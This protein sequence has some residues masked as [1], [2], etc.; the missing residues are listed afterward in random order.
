MQVRRSLTV[1]GLGAALALTGGPAWAE[2]PE[3]LPEG[4]SYVDEPVPD[5]STGGGGVE[6]EPAPDETGTAE[7]EPDPSATE[8]P[9]VEDPTDAPTD[10]PTDEPA[11][12]P[13]EEPGTDPTGG[14]GTGGGQVVVCVTGAQAGEGFTG[15]GG[16][17]TAVPGQAPAQLPTTG[18]STGSAALLGLSL[19][20]GGT[21]V[22][23]SARQPRRT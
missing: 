19:L 11:D 13:S 14:P 21:A 2:E 20:V 3:P 12:L 6:P 1:I 8:E 17:V 9:P 4:C 22:V 23:L 15:G 16:G 5:E 7:P 18:S 10:E